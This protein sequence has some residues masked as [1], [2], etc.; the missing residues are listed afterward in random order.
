MEA[1][2]ARGFTLVELMV[3]I[4][5]A[6]IV[7]VSAYALF[8]NSS[9]AMYEVDDLSKLGDQARFAAE[10]I[11]RD[12][13]SAGS[14]STPNS[15]TDKFVNPSSNGTE[16]PLDDDNFVRAIYMPDLQDDTLGPQVSNSGT[17]NDE[18][19]LLGAYDYPFTFEISDLVEQN[20]NEVAQARV[21]PGPRGTWKFSR[22]DPFDV[23]AQALT[24]PLTTGQLDGLVRPTR[25]RLMRALDRNGYMMFATIEPD[26]VSYVNEELVFDFSDD[27]R[28]FFRQGNEQNG[29]E[30]AAT[31]DEGYE[32]ALLDAF[33]YR[34]C[35]SIEDPDNLQLVRE[36][37]DPAV[38]IAEIGSLSRPSV[39]GELDP[40][41][42]LLEQVVVADR[43]VDF[44]VWF[45]C[46][47]VGQNL[48]EE[49][50]VTPDWITP[51]AVGTDA[52][53]NC[54]RSQNLTAAT[55]ND[56]DRARVAHI[57]LSMRTATERQNLANYRFITDG[58]P[59]GTTTNETNAAI[60]GGLQ[61]FDVDGDPSSASRVVTVQLD[62]DMPNITNRVNR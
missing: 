25:T 26:G 35:A 47:E 56:A 15:F 39:C 5:V 8:S 61:T 36:R 11:A 31:E 14:L 55:Y 22:R 4:V 62:L 16:N 58:N 17:S 10:L 37:L 52:N 6:G 7:V 18:I 54:M 50:P 24:D 19:I 21:R 48:I 9:R 34:V 13:R 32:A 41:N 33:R 27:Q 2:G 20:G 44:Q 30:P 46:T 57:R 40:A 38:V 28:F 1:G 3:A 59:M 29:F 42:G 51:D 12:V 43:V 23:R 45:D 49:L 53:H 60:I